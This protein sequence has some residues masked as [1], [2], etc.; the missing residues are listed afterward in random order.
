MNN[1]IYIEMLHHTIQPLNEVIHFSFLLTQL[2][3][4]IVI[5]QQQAMQSPPLHTIA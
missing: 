5:E 3:I 1:V 4:D 2:K